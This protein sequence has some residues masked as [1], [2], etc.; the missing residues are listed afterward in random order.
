MPLIARFSGIVDHFA[1]GQPLNHLFDDPRF[2]EATAYKALHLILAKGLLIFS[3]KSVALS[4]SDR[5][6][7]LK[8]LYSQFQNKNQ[9]EVWDLLVGMAGGS[10]SEPQFVISEFKRM[11][12]SEPSPNEADAARIYS[13]LKGIAEEAMK[14]AQGG[15]REKIK[16]EVAKQEL[17]A[18]LKAASIFEEAKVAL[19]K[20]QYSQAL[21]LLAR[22]AQMD[23]SLGKLKLYMIWARLGKAETQSQDKL[24]LLKEIEMDLLAVPPEEKFEALYSFVMGMFN[25]AKG[26]FPSAK[27]SFEKAYNLDNNLIQARREIAALMQKTQKKDVMNADLKDLVAGFFKKR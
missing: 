5:L 27:K 6:K 23:P 7:S 20:A 24:Q 22:A 1:S 14:F 26:D 16:E 15:N 21:P 25:K 8:S 12:G 9:L 4:P 2:P 11:I 18:K 10:D 13:H 17:E 3:D 19:N